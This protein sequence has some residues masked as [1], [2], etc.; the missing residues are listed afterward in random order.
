MSLAV[1]IRRQWCICPCQ[2]PTDATGEAI[3]AH[4]PRRRLAGA[5]DLGNVYPLK[6]FHFLLDFASRRLRISRNSVLPTVYPIPSWPSSEAD[7]SRPTAD[8]V[9]S[10]PPVP[11]QGPGIALALRD[12]F[13]L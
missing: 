6:L 3:Q 13:S 11:A 7:V 1:N 8:T 12:R 4:V 2:A 10:L 9:W 5:W